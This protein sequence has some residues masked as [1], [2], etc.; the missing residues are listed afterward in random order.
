MAT[1]NEIVKQKEQKKQMKKEKLKEN[2]DVDKILS[3]T[4][5]NI[6]KK[7]KIK[8]SVIKLSDNQV[9]EFPHI[10]TGSLSLDLALGIGGLP[11]GRIIELWGNEG[12]AKSSLCLSAVANV[13]K[14]GGKALYV[15]LEDALDPTF[16]KKLGVNIDDLYISNPDDGESAFEVIKQFIN[17]RL[18]DIIIVDSTA[19]LRPRSELEGD[20]GD[21]PMAKQAR[22]LSQSLRMLSHPIA[23][24]GT[25]VVFISQIRQKVGIIFGSKDKVGIGEAM[26][27]YASVRMKLTRT[28]NLKKGDD[29]YG[30]H[31]KVTIQKNK[32]SAPYKTAEFDFLFDSGIS[33]EGDVFDIGVKEGLIE[34]AGTW[35]SYKDFKEQGKESTVKWLV[36]NPDICNEIEKQIRQLFNDRKKKKVTPEQV[37]SEKEMDEKEVFLDVEEKVIKGVD[38]GIEKK[39]RRKVKE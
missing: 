19:A 22:L 33:R 21:A 31:V 6:D 1:Y 8:K 36:E 9:D 3:D 2:V 4:I 27:F 7:L 15:D 29:V 23:E 25:T 14:A 35:F 10:P 17:T 24:S 39:V 16:A 5:K 11:R 13:Q 30:I 37:E 34:K 18:I 26:K 20:F 32:L 12:S 28:G 38:E